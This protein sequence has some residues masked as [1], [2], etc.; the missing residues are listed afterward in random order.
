MGMKTLRL[1]KN[2]TII[3]GILLI[4][5]GLLPVKSFSKVTPVHASSTL[6]ALGEDCGADKPCGEN[7]VCS[8]EGKCIPAKGEN[9]KSGVGTN[10]VQLPEG[11]IYGDCQLVNEGMLASCQQLLVSGPD[12]CPNPRPC[13]GCIPDKVEV[14]EPAGICPACGNNLVE[15]EVCVS[16][17]CTQ[18]MCP[19][20]NPNCNTC[21]CTST[22]IDYVPVVESVPDGHCGVIQCEATGPYT[23]SPNPK[24]KPKPIIPV[25]GVDQAE[26]A[27]TL[28]RNLGMV[29]VGLGLIR[30]GMRKKK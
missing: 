13:D 1:L 11:C 12:T 30:A 28:L 18:Q 8:S 17:A 22:R 10:V 24:P 5:L 20:N 2:M 25:T 23:G 7:E 15:K 3:M 16:Y 6:L 21:G 4:A 14:C 26:L 27:G 29:I 9:E 19:D